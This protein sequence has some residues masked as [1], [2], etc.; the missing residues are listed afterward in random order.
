[1]NTAAQERAG[2]DHDYGRA[3]SPA[4]DRLDPADAVTIEQQTRD[5]SL[6]GDE[7]RV[8]FE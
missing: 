4:L 1:M 8:F 3:K 2:R 5:R 7:A 6:D